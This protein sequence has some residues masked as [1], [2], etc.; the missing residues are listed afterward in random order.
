MRWMV[1]ARVLGLVA[2][3]AA[4][5]VLAPLVV[6]W[7]AGRPVR[8][9]LETLLVCV[10]VG[11]ALHAAGR[12]GGAGV[13]PL[14]GAAITTG[15]WLLLSLLAGWGIHRAA[16]QTTWIEG[17]F[18]A[19][20]ALTT[21]GASVFGAG[22]RLAFAT[23]TPGALLWRAICCA[24]GGIGV[25]VM[26]V[27]LL[28]LIGSS[29][30]QLF[31]SEVSGLAT[32]RLTPRLADTARLI[33]LFNLA[34]IALLSGALHLAGAGW[35]DAVCHALATISTAGFSSYEASAD[36]L[37]AAGQ[38]L[39][40][41]GMVVGGTN[42]ALVIA[43][44]R[45]R[46]GPLWR[47]EEARTYAAL[48]LGLSAI[49]VLALVWHGQS[50]YAGRGI[51]ETVRHGVF[52]TVSLATSTGFTLGYEVVP[53][54]W[55]AWPA[56]AQAALL[57]ACLGLACAGSTGGGIKAVRVLLIVKLAG[58]ALRQFREPALVAPVALDGRPLSERAV[59]S[60]CVVLA[61]FALSWAVGTLVLA[62]LTA[63]DLGSAASAALSCLANIGPGFGQVGPERSFAHLGQDGLAV[64]GCLMLVGRLEFLAVLALLARR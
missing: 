4:P 38:W 43:A 2:L 14:D 48:L 32:D 27:S 9:W 56:P 1:V 13:T 37:S 6:D 11:I 7:A 22:E 61:L 47:S 55:N 10:V 40:I 54:S 53:A 62:T 46:P 5:L 8:P 31:R 29:G 20:S 52:A 15:A 26:T 28:P 57:L 42:A 17:W 34:A 12:R 59:L 44:L 41:A 63:L 18:E 19:M 16:P 58:R 3:L 39:L 51:E 24:L 23:L 50:P 45:G 30:F 49:V 25:V 36:G 35:L 64:A 33:A 21:T 60:A